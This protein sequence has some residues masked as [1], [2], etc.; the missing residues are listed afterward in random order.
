MMAPRTLR[1]CVDWR[2]NA[3]VGSHTYWGPHNRID[4]RSWMA[5]PWGFHDKDIFGSRLCYR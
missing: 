5:S 4:A 1:V 3:I 2:I